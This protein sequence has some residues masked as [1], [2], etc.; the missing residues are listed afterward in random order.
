MSQ[1]TKSNLTWLLIGVLFVLLMV[2]VVGLAPYT[3]KGPEVTFL[4]LL[5]GLLALVVVM[6]F[7]LSLMSAIICLALGA[8]Q[9][10]PGQ[11][12]ERISLQSWLIW[13]LASA[14]IMVVTLILLNVMPPGWL[15]PAPF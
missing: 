15:P 11:P 2:G 12:L 7:V 13:F 10:I 8:G 14:L 6:L 1:L 5:K 3:P 9:F 4:S